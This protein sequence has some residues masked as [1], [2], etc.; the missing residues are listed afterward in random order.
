MQ[1][2]HV[3]KD[4]V[5]LNYDYIADGIYVGSNQCCVMGLDAVLKKEGI[6]ADISLEE[7][8]LDQPFGVEAYLWMPIKNHTAPT[9][10]QLSLG[11][12]TLQTLVEQGKKVYVHCQNG[13]GRAP[14]MV[15]AYLISKGQGVDEA[16]ALV[17]E[18]RPAAHL[19]A[20]Q[21][22]ALENFSHSLRNS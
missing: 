19:Q 3:H 18:K 13:H 9:P 4:E 1:N 6:A 16:I 2:E 8:R 14:T 5:V 12:R 7:A 10:D 21:R 15:V 17:T 22:T 20:V 11:V